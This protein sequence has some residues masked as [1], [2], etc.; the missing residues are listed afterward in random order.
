MSAT[1]VVSFPVFEIPEQVMRA[2]VILSWKLYDSESTVA[3]TVMSSLFSVIFH[4]LSIALISLTSGIRSS[5]ITVQL[6]KR[7]GVS[8]TLVL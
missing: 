8:I 4:S 7:A 5:G 3:T 1:C 6:I 2:E